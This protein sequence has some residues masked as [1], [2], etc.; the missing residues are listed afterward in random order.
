MILCSFSQ[1]SPIQF[2]IDDPERKISN[3][4][5]YFEIIR[6]QKIPISFEYKKVQ[7]LISNEVKNGDLEKIVYL[8][9]IQVFLQQA[10]MNGEKAKAPEG[11]RKDQFLRDV[12]LM[13]QF[14]DSLKKLLKIN[15]QLTDRQISSIGNLRSFVSTQLQAKEQFDQSL[16]LQWLKED[17]KF[18]MD[19][20]KQLA[21]QAASD[22]CALCDQEVVLGNLNCIQM[23]KFNRCCYTNL[24][25]R[26]IPYSL[27]KSFT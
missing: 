24:Q 5:E 13:I 18:T 8:L 15:T 22:K 7:E 6:L 4:F 3:H 17:F 26:L 16:L 11:K 10:S 9:K 21:R 2:A 12:V 1:M 19:K 27:F 20:C 23:H 14:H 25:V